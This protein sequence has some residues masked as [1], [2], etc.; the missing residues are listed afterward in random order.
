[1]SGF[2]FL[3]LDFSTKYVNEVV[4]FTDPAGQGLVLLRDSNFLSEARQTVL[5]ACFSSRLQGSLGTCSYFS[6][7]GQRQVGSGT[8]R[9][10][11]DINEKIIE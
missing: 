5:S 3:L 10:L 9:S 6:V 11:P 1:M 2:D 7:W 4:G 8:H